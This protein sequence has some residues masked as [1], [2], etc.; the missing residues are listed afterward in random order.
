MLPFVPFFLL[1]N[2]GRQD[3]LLR[4]VLGIRITIKFFFSSQLHDAHIAPPVSFGRA[5]KRV[6]QFFVLSLDRI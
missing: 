5:C 2:Q 1:T 3:F 4:E 6:S